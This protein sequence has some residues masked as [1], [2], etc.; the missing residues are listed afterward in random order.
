MVKPTHGANPYD[1]YWRHVAQH[2]ES[3]AWASST[4]SPADVKRSVPTSMVGWEVKA[5]HASA[6]GAHG[7]CGGGGGEDGVMGG[8]G[9]GDGGGVAGGSMGGGTD[10]GAGGVGAASK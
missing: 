3:G 6:V 9:G 7:G 4:C 10:G 2:A 1:A 8:G 5:A